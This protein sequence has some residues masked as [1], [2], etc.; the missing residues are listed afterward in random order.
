MRFASV[1]ASLVASS[2]LTLAT[3]AHADDDEPA[4]RSPGVAIGLSVAGGV[5]GVLGGALTY[6][7]LGDS[8]PAVGMVF[9]GAGAFLLAPTAGQWYAGRIVTPGL[10]LRAV[11][12]VLALSAI[13]PPCDGL[14]ACDPHEDRFN[15]PLLTAAVAIGVGG[16]V[17][18]VATAGAAA[19]DFNREHAR[20]TV[21]PTA[22]SARDGLVPG[23]A[24]MGSF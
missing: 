10:G 24:V 21:A 18:D 8:E 15:K 22:L 12:T 3:T 9:A 11:G 20:I 5:V 1:L 6:T 14:S 2:V 7:A 19:D 23:L 13:K 4:T 16:L 17:W